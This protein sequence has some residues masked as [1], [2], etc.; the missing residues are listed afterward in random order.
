MRPTRRIV[1]MS[2]L[3]WLV[4]GVSAKSANLTYNIVAYPTITS[5]YSV[6]GTIT[7]NGATGTQLPATD[8]IG[9]DITVAQDSN[10]IFDITPTTSGILENSTF[11]ATTTTITVG[12]FTNTNLGDNITFYLIT[13]PYNYLEWSGPT[14]SDGDVYYGM[15]FE[16]T[17]FPVY[18]S[19]WYGH[20]T[21]IQDPVAIEVSVPEPSTG[22][23]A[24]FGAVSALA[25]AQ[26]RKRQT[27]HARGDG[28]RSEPAE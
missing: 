12:T 5:P 14:Q 15:F 10:Q 9:W 4:L 2:V 26:K 1:M 7:T 20:F 22:V 25:Y 21:S 8:I 17:H 23:L 28:G 6:S 19:Y 18:Y 24:G 27:R 3:T 13:H 11:D 16:E